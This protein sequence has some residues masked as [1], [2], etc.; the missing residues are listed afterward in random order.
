MSVFITDELCRQM[1]ELALRHAQ[2]TPN[3]RLSLEVDAFL[4]WVRGN[5][6]KEGDGIMHLHT[7]S[8]RE[9]EKPIN[10]QVIQLSK[11]FL[12][13]V[14]GVGICEGYIDRIEDSSKDTKILFFNITDRPPEPFNAIKEMIK[15]LA[16]LEGFIAKKIEGGYPIK[17]HEFESLMG[18]I[19]NARRVADETINKNQK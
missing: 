10:P 14:P 15:H 8:L 6:K 12:M 9:K 5:I 7:V 18:R 13:L 2:T 19:Q 1:E 16:F 3:K 17:T 4:T 11:P